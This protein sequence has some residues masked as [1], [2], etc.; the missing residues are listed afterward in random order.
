MFVHNFCVI[1]RL[2]LKTNQ[3]K[4]P[5]IVIF[6]PIIL[7]QSIKSDHRHF[8]PLVSLKNTTAAVLDDFKCSFMSTKTR[9]G[10]EKTKYAPVLRYFPYVLQ[11]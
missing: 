10:S 11:G 4:P 5:N 9:L 8:F 3:V 6:P 7:S 2:F 1:D